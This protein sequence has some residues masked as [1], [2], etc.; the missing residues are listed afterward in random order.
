M[1]QPAPRITK[2]MAIALSNRLA[3]ALTPGA[4]TGHCMVDIL[5]LFHVPFLRRVN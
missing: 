4:G 5:R 3:I 1:N 2:E